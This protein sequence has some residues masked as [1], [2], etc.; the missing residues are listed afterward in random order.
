[1]IKVSVVIPC[2]N[3][4][5]YLPQCFL[6]LAEQT[7]GIE[8]IE[9]IFVDDASDDDGKTWKM[10]REFEQAYSENVIIIHLEDNMRQGGARNAGIA[11]AS[12]EYLAFV[13]ADDFVDQYLLEK[14]Y[15][16]A[17]ET[18]ADIVQFGFFYYKAGIG[19]V[20]VESTCLEE[21]IRITS[22]SERKQFLISEKITYGCWNKLYRREFVV[23]A[24]VRFAEHVI[25]EEPLF[26][27]PL[28]F[29]GKNYTIMNERFYYYRQNDNG[30][31]RSDMKQQET[32]FMHADVQHQVWDFMKHTDYFSVYREEIKLYFLHTYFYET[33]YF[34]KKR[35]FPVTMEFYQLLET[36]VKREVPDYAVSVYET[37]IPRQL[38]LYRMAEMGMEEAELDKYMAAL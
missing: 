30:T 8:N 12:G 11:Y 32:L 17:I 33:L 13:D 6:S 20:P 18:D 19:A 2:H 14:T 21:K 4:A 38:E 16:K 26:V 24:G 5:R 29:S 31:M 23:R 28:L 25:Y 34:A 1:M 10:L 37:L 35:G 9:L 7:I 3:A 27:Y 22:V 15:Q 36:E